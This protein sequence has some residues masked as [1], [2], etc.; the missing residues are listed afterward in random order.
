MSKI[1]LYECNVC[2]DRFGAANDVLHFEVR[3]HRKGRPFENT[4]SNVTICNPDLAGFDG[5][6]PTR[7][8]YLGVE[9]SEIVGGVFPVGYDG[10]DWAPYTGRD[11]AR[12]SAFDSF[13]QY[14]ETDVL[15]H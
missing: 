4:I 5:E 13:F 10:D 15:G 1:T 6:I 7:I 14:V 12:L 8:E 2:G 9:D 3:R 11:N